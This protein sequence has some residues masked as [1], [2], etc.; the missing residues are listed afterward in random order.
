[1]KRVGCDWLV[2]TMCRTEICWVTRGPRWGPRGKG[3]TSG[4]CR[5]RAGGRLCHP[6]C[7]NCH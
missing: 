5:C 4:G 1:M 3:D 7:G 2:C 6:Q